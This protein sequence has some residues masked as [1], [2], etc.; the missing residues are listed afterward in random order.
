MIYKKFII[1]IFIST[2]LILGCKN[3]KQINSDANTLN[4]YIENFCNTP[5]KDISKKLY[6]LKQ[7]QTLYK[8]RDYKPIWFNKSVKNNSFEKTLKLL[9]SSMNY[10]LDTIIYK[11]HLIEKVSNKNN[12]IFQLTTEL[13]TTNSV[14]LF[15]NH[16]ERGIIFGDTT[17][18]G[19]FISEIN[20]TI[21]YI[22]N[23]YIEKNKT[24]EGI[25]SVEP[26]NPHYKIFKIA[27]TEYLK[28]NK[29]TNEKYPIP[30]FV[31][32]PI[33]CREGVEKMLILNNYLDKDSLQSKENIKKALIK[34]QTDHGL[35][36]KGG[37]DTLTIES[38]RNSKFDNYRKA[39]LTLQR[40]RWS[41]INDNNYILVNIP[42]FS[43]NFIEE[44]KIVFTHRIICGDR[45]NNTP[46][47]NSN[48]SKIIL[49]PD[50]NVPFS[51]S[52]KELLPQIQNDTNYIAHHRYQVF[53]GKEEVDPKTVDWRK[54][55]DKH[56]PYRIR[57]TSGDHNS[58]G[59]IKFYFSNSYG[60]YLHDTPGK[61]LFK[62]NYR[63][64]S[65]GCMRLQ[66]PRQFAHALLEYNKGY[67]HLSKQDVQNQNMQLNKLLGAKDI[68]KF[69]KN[70]SSRTKTTFSINKNLPIYV[71]YFSVFFDENQKLTFHSDLYHKDISLY[72]AFDKAIKKFN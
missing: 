1:I 33:K 14:L 25:L 20:D 7:L 50:W 48:I 11:A 15:M 31:N 18:Y 52:S 32:N 71:R 22:L 72:I 47:L 49:F 61:N 70:I 62:K 56:F 35:V 17:I 3:K 12:I 13:F 68:E 65:H 37:Y 2:F 51:I 23:S 29:I 58:L 5:N 39:C 28:N 57:Q 60:V 27:L 44:N 24:I 38:L 69:N 19:N 64:F 45:D 21:P 67:V 9:K 66:N 63:A 55:N 10:G 59:I 8:L 30:Y 54:Y 43:L 16:I 42:S 34:Y 46:E 41:F 36:T 4:F 26:Q 40:M 53:K 6:A